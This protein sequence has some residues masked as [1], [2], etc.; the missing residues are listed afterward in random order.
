VPQDEYQSLMGNLNQTMTRTDQGPRSGIR[1]RKPEGMAQGSA[2]LV[3]ELA[4]EREAAT[5]RV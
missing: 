4:V 3:A 1:G 5:G 2:V